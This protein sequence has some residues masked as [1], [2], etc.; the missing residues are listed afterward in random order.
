M[1]TKE[2][3]SRAR[4][5]IPPRDGVTTKRRRYK[6]EE[7]GESVNENSVTGSEEFSRYG[8]IIRTGG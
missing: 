3:E 6:D 7:N 1:V 2:I 8:P 5:R 4:E